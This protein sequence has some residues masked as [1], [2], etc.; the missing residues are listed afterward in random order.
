MGNFKTDYAATKLEITE[1]DYESLITIILFGNTLDDNVEAEEMERTYGAIQYFDVKN[2]SL[3]KDF[4]A[5]HKMKAEKWG[6]KQDLST[7]IAIMLD[8]LS[9]TEFF[10]I[11]QNL[12]DTFQKYSIYYEK[13]FNDVKE[14]DIKKICFSNNDFAL[15]FYE[16]ERIEPMSIVEKYANLMYLSNQLAHVFQQANSLNIDKRE[17]RYHMKHLIYQLRKIKEYCIHKIIEQKGKGE[18]VEI[19]IREDKSQKSSKN[20]VLSV[21]IPNYFE[22]FS[23]HMDKTKFSEEELKQCNDRDCYYELNLRTTFPQYIGPEKMHYF[24]K[25]YNR[26]FHRGKNTRR[27]E[28]LRLK[29]LFEER[30][31]LEKQ[32]QE[33]KDNPSKFE[34]KYHGNEESKQAIDIERENREVLLDL[35]RKL[36][37]ELS[38]EFKKGFL[39]RTKYSLKKY[40]KTIS[41]EIKNQLL[42][43]GM[44]AEKIDS[45]FAKFIIYM[46]STSSLSTISREKKGSIMKKSKEA[47]ADYLIVADSITEILSTTKDYK[48]FKI[49]IN[50]LL[51]ASKEIQEEKIDLE[52]CTTAHYDI[53]EIERLSNECSELS[54]EIQRLSEKLNLKQ[55][56]LAK[57][58]RRLK[59]KEREEQDKGDD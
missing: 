16:D 21:A 40:I 57:A 14:E 51:S 2:K 47:L 43:L 53:S 52:E 20:Y 4:S 25:I 59:P 24:E 58:I 35:E 37:A 45:E 41:E 56:E 17:E 34:G 1:D 38:E 46:K 19:A 50:K 49:Q 27:F 6:E 15:Q 36:G 18:N 13:S 5:L 26:Y 48:S 28:G 54:N 8:L 30:Q 10:D 23:V 9:K 55:K 22:P 44:P 29:W 31:R 42:N 12:K 32:K 7:I 11:Q 39:D 33:L 3:V